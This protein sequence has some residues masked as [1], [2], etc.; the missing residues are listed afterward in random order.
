MAAKNNDYNQ[1]IYT[2]YI[3]YVDCDSGGLDYSLNIDIPM[4]L[5]DC[6]ECM[7]DQQ[8]N[9]YQSSDFNQGVMGRGLPQILIRHKVIIINTLSSVGLFL[10]SSELK[11]VWSMVSKNQGCVVLETYMNCIIFGVDLQ[12][13]PQRAQQDIYIFF[14]IYHN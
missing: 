11:R 9:Y 4:N 8:C 5:F 13:F 14:T 1:V 10:S 3:I 2:T 7:S 12:Y 6:H